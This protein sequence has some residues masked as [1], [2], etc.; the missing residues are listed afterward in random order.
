M[1]PIRNTY[2]LLITVMAFMVVGAGLFI[3][4]RRA[5]EESD[6]PLA[7]A[8]SVADARAGGRLVATLY[9]TPTTIAS[10]TDT[11]RV[12]EAWVERREWVHYSFLFIK[13]HTL[14]DTL[15]LVIRA[16]TPRGS[17]LHLDLKTFDGRSLRTRSQRGNRIYYLDDLGTK[18]PER[19]MVNVYDRGLRQLLGSFTLLARP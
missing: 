4:L 3:Q 14:S 8:V 16:E 6:A 5:Q 13:Q 9:G 15:K 12:L 7:T 11:L 17:E 18:V 19:V 1:R 2:A 10:T